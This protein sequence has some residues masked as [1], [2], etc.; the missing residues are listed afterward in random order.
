[1]HPENSSTGTTGTIDTTFTSRTGTGH[2]CIFRTGIIYIRLIDTTGIT[3]TI[4]ITST[5][6]T[7]ITST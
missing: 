5:F 1:M 3:S 7:A 2:T 6:H 4:A